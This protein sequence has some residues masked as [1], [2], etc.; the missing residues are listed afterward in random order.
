VRVEGSEDFKRAANALTGLGDKQLRLATGRGL[1]TAAKPLGEAM[2]RAGAADMPRRGGLSA[3][4][5]ASKVGVTASLTGANPRVLIRLRTRQG[6]DL[7]GMD[8]GQVRH[9][10]FSRAGRRPT[11]VRQSVPAGSFTRAFN[12]GAPQVREALSRQIQQVVNAAAR[13]V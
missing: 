9:P 5:A 10:V 12:A 8:R 2:V 6:D 4:V 3:R 11:W 1:R 13:K 7:S